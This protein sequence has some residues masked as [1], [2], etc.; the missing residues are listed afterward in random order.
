MRLRY[1]DVR[2]YVKLSN[3]AREY[4][5]N[6]LGKLYGVEEL[7][8][9]KEDITLFSLEKKGYLATVGDRVTYTVL[10]WGLTPDIAVVDCMERRK[11]VN[12]VDE[13]F[14]NSVWY[15]DNRRGSINMAIKDLIVNVLN[16]T[17]VLIKV[18][19]EDD[20][21]G[22]PVIYSLPEGSLMLYGQP[23]KGIV[24]VDVTSMLK[25]ELDKIIFG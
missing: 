4:L 22:I 5:A 15:V 1:F 14:F 16:D 18:G 11:P 9:L 8:V 6:P 25:S 12:L 3:T 2:R 10:E 24:A 21:V 13:S 17:P 20:L 23:M 19:G 7:D